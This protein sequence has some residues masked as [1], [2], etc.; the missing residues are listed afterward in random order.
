MAI[1]KTVDTRVSV[2]TARNL[3]TYEGLSTDSKPTRGVAVNSRFTELDTGNVYFYNGSEWKGYAGGA[4]PAPPPD[5]TTATV[6][7]RI[8]AYGG[9]EVTL[10]AALESGL[11]STY[12]S[13]F[14]SSQSLN[15]ILYKGHAD[16]YIYAQDGYGLTIINTTG[17][18]LN[19]GGYMFD[20]YGDGTIEAEIKLLPPE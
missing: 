3:V 9:G 17:D 7:I 19:T 14:G 4:D 15:V 6:E 12:Q 8:T 20:V 11:K 1:T 16:M 2:D 5:Y 13:T 18:I 10:Q